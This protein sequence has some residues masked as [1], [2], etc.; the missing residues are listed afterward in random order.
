MYR[1]FIIEQPSAYEN[2]H[3]PFSVTTISFLQPLLTHLEQTSV[4]IE[5]CLRHFFLP[6]NCLETD[7]LFAWIINPPSP[8][9]AFRFIPG[10]NMQNVPPSVQND[11]SNSGNAL[12]Q[13]KEIPVLRKIEWIYFLKYI[14]FG[15]Q[16]IRRGVNLREKLLRISTHGTCSC[17]IRLSTIPGEDLDGL[18]A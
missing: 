1:G 16:Y 18:C 3:I 11:P 6:L 10:T 7:F 12:K 2:A 5:I 9:F 13:G 8:N 14:R 15:I 17:P 4:A